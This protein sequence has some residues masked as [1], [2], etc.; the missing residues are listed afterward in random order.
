MNEYTSFVNLPLLGLVYS[1]ML[2]IQNTYT[3]ASLHLCAQSYPQGCQ[4]GSAFVQVS[5]MAISAAPQT[6]PERRDC[7][8]TAPILSER[9]RT[10]GDKP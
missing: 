9:R 2:Q 6:S 5:L 4:H 8:A 1:T 10:A 3:H 7:R